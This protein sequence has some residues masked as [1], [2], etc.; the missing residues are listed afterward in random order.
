MRR[1]NTLEYI[2]KP[3]QQS[4]ITLIELLVTVAVLS[5]M[6][7]IAIPNYLAMLPGMRLNGATR[8]VMG[9]LM[10]AR[11]KA[12]KENNEYK[13]FFLNNHQYKI[14][15]DD[16]NDGNEDSG[17]AAA[18]KDIQNEYYDVSFNATANPIFRPRGTASG[19]TISIQNSSGSKS[20][21]INLT[22]RVK[23]N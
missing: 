12:V 7:A 18:S 11:M 4:G 1:S 13:V 10:G 20:I 17:E 3:G 6:A 9:D 8:M 2:E 15:D 22:G 14:L 19:S 5:I 16:N 23:L 21:T